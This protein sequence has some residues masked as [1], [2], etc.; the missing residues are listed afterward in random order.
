MQWSKQ[1]PVQ[2]EEKPQKKN[3]FMQCLTPHDES[4]KYKS[5]LQKLTNKLIGNSRS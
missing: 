5:E 4:N 3:G 1:K 2:I